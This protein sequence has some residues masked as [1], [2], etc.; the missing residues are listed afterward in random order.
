MNLRHLPW[1]ISAMPRSR[2]R[3]QPRFFLFRWAARL[4][5]VP[6]VGVYALIVYFTQYVSWYGASA[7][8]NSMLSWFPSPFWGF[9]FSVHRSSAGLRVFVCELLCAVRARLGKS[10]LDKQT[11]LTFQHLSSSIQ[12]P[13]LVSAPPLYGLGRIG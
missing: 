2:R 8:T 3:E 4:S 6:V 13:Q 1:E 10:M 7:C 5:T 9:E 11:T 12:H